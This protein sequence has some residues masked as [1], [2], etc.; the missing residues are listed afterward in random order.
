MAVFKFSSQGILQMLTPFLLR[1]LTGRA[2]LRK[3]CMAV[4]GVLVVAGSIGAA[5]A[6]S[7]CALSIKVIVVDD[8]F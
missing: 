7:V 8:I 2:H 6:P 3:T 4:G 1:F 5:F